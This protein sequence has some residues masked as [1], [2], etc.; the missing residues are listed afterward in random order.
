M[1]IFTI[2]ETMEDVLEKSKNL[3]FSNKVVVDKEELLDLIKEMRLKLPD[4]LGKRR[5]TKNIS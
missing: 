2:I 1:E 5:K 4:E 3:L